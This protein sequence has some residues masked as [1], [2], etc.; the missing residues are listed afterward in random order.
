MYPLK[1][2]DYQKKIWLI[3][4][5][6]SNKLCKAEPPVNLANM[7]KLYQKEPLKKKKKPSKLFTGANAQAYQ[8]SQPFN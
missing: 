3:S 1:A 8:N 2:T 5:L 6:K 4:K 7:K